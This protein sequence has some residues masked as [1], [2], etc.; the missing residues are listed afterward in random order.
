VAAARSSAS[1]FIIP[2][3]KCFYFILRKRSHMEASQYKAVK[4]RTTD[5]YVAVKVKMERRTEQKQTRIAT[6]CTKKR[7]I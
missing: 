3:E 5:D 6:K 1:G 7:K 4:L 2:V